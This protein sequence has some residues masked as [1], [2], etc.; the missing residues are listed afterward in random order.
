MKKLF[1]LLTLLSSNV[2]AAGGEG[3]VFSPTIMYRSEAVKPENGGTET[4]S[5]EIF[6]NLK[7]AY[8][9]ASGMYLGGVYDVETDDAGAASNNGD[10][11]SYGGTIGYIGD[12]GF[13]ASFSYLFNSK[14][15][16]GNTNYDGSGYIVDVGYTFSAGSWGVGPVLQYRK[17]TYDKSG[18]ASLTS[19]REETLVIP[20]VQF[21]FQFGG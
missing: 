19:D 2:F 3:F 1:I 17:F 13:N 9:M 11:T 10:R 21:M 4:E 16:L 6:Y 12:S 5:T 8:K 20:M 14:N 18:G 15:E 7:L